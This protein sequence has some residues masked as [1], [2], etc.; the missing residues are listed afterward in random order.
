MTLTVHVL[1]ANA[2][3][4]SP[5]GGASSYLVRG[6]TGVVLVDA[7]PGSLLSFFQQGHSLD[8][9]RAIV[10][11][12]LHAD[13]SL[14]MMAWAYRW[15]FPALRESIPVYVP[16][17]EVHKLEAFD[18]LYGIPTLPTMVRPITGSFDVR[19]MPMD[20]GA[21]SVEID[22]LTLRTYRARHAVP[23]AVLRFTDSAGR[24]VT[25]SA[26]TGDCP[27][28]AAAAQDTDIFIA[29]ATYLEPDEKAMAEH[30]HLTPAL[31]GELA[32]QAGARQLVLT[33]LADPD[34]ADESARRAEETYNLG[35]V[36][37]AKAGL[38]V[39]V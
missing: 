5:H 22:G 2:T 13:H 31:A 28:L 32:T 17:G 36:S 7:G 34:D 15:T 38:T 9:L 1:G 4:P 18:D 26:D 37:V 29:E 16:T 8:E 24:S 11:T 10:L 21:S 3:A 23:A 20:D 39:S 30:G 6:D 25:F 19:E 27:G 12:H 14:D 35:P 33:H